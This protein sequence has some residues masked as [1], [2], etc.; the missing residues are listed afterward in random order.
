MGR[1]FTPE[2]VANHDV[3]EVGAHEKAGRF[4]LNQLFEPQDYWTDQDRTAFSID[5]NGIDSGLVYGS[6]ALGKA[7][8]RSDVDILL[9]YHA[10]KTDRAFPLIR[11]VFQVAENDFNVPIEPH[12]LPV[13][14]LFNPLEHSIDPLFAEHL[15]AVQYQNEP[16]WSYNWPVDG[17]QFY[18]IEATDEERLRAI[19]VRYASG[20]SRQFAK[21]VV[22]YR[23]EADLHVLQRALELPG[24]IGRK[25]IAATRKADEEAPNLGDKH[26]MSDITI[27]KLGQFAPE[28]YRRAVD[29][30]GY[31]HNLDQ[32]YDQLLRSALDGDTTV[33]AYGGWL[34]ENYLYACK[35]AHEVAYVWSQIVSC[36]M[37]IPL[38]EK[39]V[40]AGLPYESLDEDIY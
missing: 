34:Q 2:A 37:D 18:R 6:T 4:I 22:G 26:G 31:L 9:N 10:N 5:G 35:M 7:G 23:G 38:E 40:A 16:R 39:A 11:D 25:V 12:V 1:V 27:Q 15:I 20:K 28:W 32:S 3:P 21:A 13:G 8:L 36:R 17:L 24:A 29:Y 30:Q 33:E 14:A 19:A